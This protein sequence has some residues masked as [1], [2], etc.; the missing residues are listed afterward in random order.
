MI[1]TK[2]KGGEGEKRERERRRLGDSIPQ[3]SAPWP[4]LLI[5]WRGEGKV[6]IENAADGSSRMIRPELVG[7]YPHQ[8]AGGKVKGEGRKEKRKQRHFIT[9][10]EA[11]CD[12]VEAGA[13]NGSDR[14]GPM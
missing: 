3:L 5:G 2:K 12:R 13:G 14:A 4:V 8:S 6:R 7:D 11:P 9:F 1:A 10:N